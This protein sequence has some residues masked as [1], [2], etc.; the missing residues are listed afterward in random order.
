MDTRFDTLGRCQRLEQKKKLSRST[1]KPRMEYCEYQYGTIIYVRAFARPQSWR[2]TQSRS[3]SF[4]TGTLELKEHIF[5]SAA[6][7][8]T[9]QQSSSDAFH[10]CT[11]LCRPPHWARL[12]LLQAK[13]CSKVN[14]PL[15]SSR[16]RVL[17]N[18]MTYTC[19]VDQ[20]YHI[21][22]TRKRKQHFLFPA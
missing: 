5:H 21:Q 19:Q 17:A 4:E 10:F 2:R 18:E 6:L 20:K 1:V 12:L 3:V 15:Q 8:T 13:F 14:F 16:R 9:N 7:P 22:K 11:T